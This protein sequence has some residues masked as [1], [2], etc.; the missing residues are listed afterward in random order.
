[1][2]RNLSKL[3]LTILIAFLVGNGLLFFYINQVPSRALFIEPM[4]RFKTEAKIVALTFDDGPSPILT[5]RL[6]DL[7]KQ[8]RVKA[9]FFMI[10]RHVEK[11]RAIA[12]RL[13]TE[14]HGVGSHTYNHQRMIY[15]TFSFVEQDLGRMD[16]LLDSLGVDNLSFFRPPYGDKLVILPLVLKKT[17]KTLVTWDVDPSGQYDRAHHTCQQVAQDVIDQTQ[18]GSIILLHDGPGVDSDWLL[19][20]VETIITTLDAQGYEFVTIETGLKMTL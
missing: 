6:L 2:I 7:L 9:T 4:Y 15:R 13:V 17:N 16:A 20:A 12:Q 3:V 10:G 18:P 19:C 8:Y 11:N 1:M 5:P 14:G